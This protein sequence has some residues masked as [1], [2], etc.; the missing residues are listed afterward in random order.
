[1]KVQ[2]AATI[3]AI[4]SMFLLLESGVL[5]ALVAF[6]LVGAIP[7]T[8]YS[9]SPATMSFIF[10]VIFFTSAL[11]LALRPFIHRLR[12]SQQARQ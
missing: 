10:G 1:M 5:D 3:T 7:G 4:V 6:I 2:L 12:V 8:P 11:H 9:L